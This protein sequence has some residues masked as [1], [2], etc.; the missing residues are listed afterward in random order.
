MS[1]EL[2]TN[3]DYSFKQNRDISWLRFNRRVLEEAEDS[4]IP[5]LERLKFVA[6]YATNLDEFFMIRVGSLYDELAYAP[7]AIDTKS[8]LTP[9]EQLSKIYGMVA[10]LNKDYNKCF[11]KV[12]RELKSKSIESLDISDLNEQEHKFVKKY[13]TDTIYPLLSP[14]IVD[15][16]HP[17]P[18]LA[19][20]SIYVMCM[21]KQK[22]KKILGIVPVPESIPPLLTM[23]VSSVR[24]IHTEKIISEYLGSIFESYQ[25]GERTCLSVTRNAD[26][27]SDEDMF[28]ENVDFRKRMKKLLKERKKLAVVRVETSEKLSGEFTDYICKRLEITNNQI[29]V[30]DAPIRMNYVYSLIGHLPKSISEPLLYNHYEPVNIQSLTDKNMFQIV[31]KKDM[32]F[33]YPY[34]SIK[35]FLSLLKQAA[36]DP[37]VISIRITIYRL[38]LKANIVDYLCSAAENGK[39]VTVIIELRARFDE[40]NNIDWSEKL[41][42]AGCKIIYGFEEY[43]VHSKVCLITYKDKGKIKYVTQIG[44]GNYNEKTA[45]LYTDL[46]FI[47]GNYEIGEDAAEFF[48]NM[49]IGNLNGK[50]KHLLVAPFGLKAGI[51]SLIDEE[52]TKGK[53]GR[54]TIKANSLTDIDVINKLSEASIAGVRISMVIRGICCILPG[55]E[56]KTD[57]I[58]V[59]SV[60]GRFLEHS[61]IYSFGYG[62]SQKIFISSADLMTRNLNRR[63]EV[64]C[65]I[66]DPE[67]KNEINKIL[68]IMLYDN[69]KARVIDSKGSFTRIPDNRISINSQEQF[70]IQAIQQK[71]SKSRYQI[72]RFRGLKDYVRNSLER[73]FG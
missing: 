5:L 4:Y 52:I 41:E 73:L 28:S 3:Q 34:F 35:P 38:A 44:T 69:V 15:T 68:D 12:E 30:M 36:N 8:G 31:S 56:G 50:Y 65:P 29:Y 2:L 62:D 23:P 66:Y 27:S 13:F 63:V 22:N 71:Y 60:V 16:H 25:I 26:I 9:G 43:K 67:I 45:E 42:D 70:M 21:L 11:L 33:H 49:S 24:Y 47:T 19:N 59:K 54:I 58:K 10:E 6:I 57:N 48:K 14:Q 39:D 40:Q 37:N 61:R 51:L 64:A 7:T 32:L 55:V 20:K 53:E 46:S 17:F 1:D 72:N 18:H